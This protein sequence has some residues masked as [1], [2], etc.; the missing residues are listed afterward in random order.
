MNTKLL[1]NLYSVSRDYNL[2]SNYKLSTVSRDY[3]LLSNLY[4]VSSKL[5]VSLVHTGPVLI[6]IL[7]I[8]GF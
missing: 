5:L 7:L 2:L 4:S 1:T 8:R 3:N 6:L